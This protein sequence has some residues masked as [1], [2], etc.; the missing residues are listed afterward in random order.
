MWST[1]STAWAAGAPQC[2]ARAATTFAP[3]PQLQEPTASIDLGDDGGCL[4]D[5]S[6]GRYALPDRPVFW[7][8]STP[9]LTEQAGEALMVPPAV[10]YLLSY[11]RH[12]D[13]EPPS[14]TLPTLD[15][16]PTR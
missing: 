5:G 7:E 15:R 14:V 8:V 11:R 1:A 9:D 16:P 3:P 6:Y 10:G 13:R 4:S 2:D 12:V